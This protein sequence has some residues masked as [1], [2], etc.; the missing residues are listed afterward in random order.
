MSI[1]HENQHSIWVFGD[2]RLMA[3]YRTTEKIDKAFNASDYQ[4][5]LKLLTP[6]AKAGDADSW[7]TIGHIY[8][9]SLHR[10]QK[11][12]KERSWNLLK[13]EDFDVWHAQD[14]IESL[15][16]FMKA[17]E[18]EKQQ[19]HL[20][21]FTE[22]DVPSLRMHKIVY[23]SPMSGLDRALIKAVL[24]NDLESVRALL[25]RGADVEAKTEN[26]FSAL[27]WICSYVFG[28]DSENSYRIIKF[29]VERGADV[30][31]RTNYGST[32]LTYVSQGGHLPAVKFLISKGAEV[33]DSEEEG[34]KALYV[35][36]IQ[37]N[38]RIAA[39]LIEHGAQ[40][41]GK[42]YCGRTPLMAAA[43]RGALS[44][45]KLL[46]S[47]GADIGVQDDD[48]KTALDVATDERQTA[49]INLLKRHGAES[50]G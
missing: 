10:F 14:S 2:N 8:Y 7:Y 4:A 50:H 39:F 38:E 21:T 11:V 42:A 48:G 33:N 6:L 15:H 41:N 36:A 20:E 17:F 12:K 24:A 29:L 40:I 30:N 47:K 13:D 32:P 31:A 46:L 9:L 27:I 35:A 49:I 19:T 25:D 34:S 3:N 16:W 5:A 1:N 45:V 43:S 22:D 37:H 23:S 18:Y 44:V 28:G 26:G